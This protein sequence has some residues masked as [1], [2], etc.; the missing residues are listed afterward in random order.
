MIARHHFTLIIQSNAFLGTERLERSLPA[1]VT[2]GYLRNWR[3]GQGGASSKDNLQTVLVPLLLV[4][5]NSAFF[6]Q[7]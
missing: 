7:S 2:R 1:V 6:Y 3:S 5:Q 4:R